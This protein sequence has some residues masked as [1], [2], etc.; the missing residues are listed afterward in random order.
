MVAPVLTQPPQTPF[1]QS[2]GLLGDASAG[3]KNIAGGGILQNIN[4][5][6]NP[7]YQQ[8]I[9]S[10]LGRMDTARDKTLGL[11][12]DQAISS[13]AF[14]GSRHGI[15]E[16]EFLGQDQ[17][18]RAE[19]IARLNAENFGQASGAVR[20]DTFGALDRMTQ[21]G[22]NY[23][24]IGTDIADRQNAAGTQQQQLLQM[25][26]SGGE[27]QFNSMIN[28]P[29]QIIN[30]FNALISSDPRNNNVTNTQQSTPGLFDYLSLAAGMGSAYLGA[31]A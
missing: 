27:Q 1:Q 9:E 30:L 18:N 19:M 20:A 14:G 22:R 8:V 29:S 5:Y 31:G 15:A 28:Q 2:A 17:L 13:G 6:I 23:Y 12:G 21:L 16:G 7:Y 25:L 3:Y 24:G 26:L 4:S 11:I 10:T